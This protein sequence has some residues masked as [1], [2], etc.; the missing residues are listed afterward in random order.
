MIAARFRAVKDGT[1]PADTVVNM[2]V[3]Q[4]LALLKAVLLSPEVIGVTVV[5]AIFLNIVNAVVYYRKKPPA[6]KSP[7]RKAAAKAAPQP[8]PAEEDE[9]ESDQEKAPPSSAGKKSRG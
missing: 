9:G 6:P 5:M 7:K 2:T 8:A 4:L 1:D 3:D